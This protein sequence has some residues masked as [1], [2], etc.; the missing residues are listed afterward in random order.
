MRVSTQ[1]H[2]ARG[3][4]RARGSHRATQ[5]TYFTLTQ[6]QEKSSAGGISLYRLIGFP[7]D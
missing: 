2:K 6:G 3:S 4:D 5:P 7:E 1:I